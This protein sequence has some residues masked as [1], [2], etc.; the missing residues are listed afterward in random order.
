MPIVDINGTAVE[1]PDDMP[2]EALNAAVAAAA[3]QMSAS[4]SPPAAPQQFSDPGE[5]AIH[6]DAA[7]M[8]AGTLRQ[9]DPNPGVPA[10]PLQYG[11]E[12][13][14]QV[15]RGARR[16][17][18]NLVG[19]PVDLATFL[20]SSASSVLPESIRPNFD[21]RRSVGGSAWLDRALG[22]FGAVPEPPAPRDA[23]QRIAGRV[24][25]ELGALVP[26]VG[27][28][29]AAARAGAT[30]T[31]NIISRMFVQPFRANPNRYV[32]DQVETGIAAGVG[33]GAVNEATRAAGAEQGGTVQQIGDIAGSLAGGAAYAAGRATGAG[34][35]NL[36]RVARDGSEAFTSPEAEE[37][38][39]H[40]IARMFGTP[41]DGDFEAVASG[42][43]RG[44]RPG[45]AIP[46]YA[47]TLADRTQNPTVAANAYGRSSGRNA[48]AYRERAASNAEA[49]D[50]AMQGAAPEGNSGALIEAVVAERTAR[51]AGATA[52]ADRLSA[53]ADR[54]AAMLFPQMSPQERGQIVRGAL[55]DAL[56]TF[57]APQRQDA[58]TVTAELA[59]VLDGLRPSE[60]GRTPEL[61]GST[62]RS[63]LASAEGTA[64]SRV[65]ALYDEAGVG[66]QPVDSTRVA[67]ALDG[68]TN[69][70]PLAE[71]DLV[72]RQIIDNVA[73][74]GRQQAAAQAAL[75]PEAD[76]LRK[77]LEGMGD[78]PSSVARQATAVP[79]YAGGGQ[80]APP[81]TLAELTALRTRL[82]AH[83]R[84]LRADPRAE[85]GGANAA[86]VTEQYINA[87][88]DL[89]QESVDPGTAARL[90]EA[91]AAARARADSFGRQGD[92]VADVLATREGG[93]P[94][95][96]DQNVPG[97]FVNSNADAP[98]GRLLE[99][100]DTPAVR[101]AIEDELLSR[102]GR[103]PTPEAAGAVLQ[104]YG[105]ALARFPG[106]RDRIQQAVATG[107]RVTDA[108]AALASRQTEFASGSSL[109]ADA[110][111][112][113]PDG[114]PVV[115][116]EAI[117]R[118]AVSPT[119]N[120]DLD[121]ILSRAN[122]PEVRG[123]LRD[124]VL[125][126]ARV[127]R[128]PA[129][130]VEA[131]IREYAEPLKR[132]PGLADE[133]RT[134][135]GARRD[136]DA[137]AQAAEQTTR[138]LTTPGRSA[139][140]TVGSFGPDEGK[141]AIAAIIQSRNPGAATDE[142]MQAIG[143]DPEAVNGAR[144]AF[145]EYLEAKSR[146][147]GETTPTPRGTQPWMPERLYQILN[148]RSVAGVAERLYRD[149]PEHL[150][151]I[152]TIA[153]AM[154]NT[155][156]DTRGRAANSS[157][158]GQSVLQSLTPEALQSRIYA[159]QSGRISYTFLATAVV[160]V[161]YRKAMRTA[162]TAAIE[163]ITDE[164]LLNPDFA[165]A[166]LRKYNPETMRALR[167]AT[168]AASL[169][170]VSNAIDLLDQSDRDPVER[171]VSER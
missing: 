8:R 18:A 93:Q 122:T 114:I 28:A 23:P 64:Q 54:L 87:V 83:A 68:V 73:A 27:G 99:E 96:P 17:V 53:E 91:R 128:N 135:A 123:A 132:F 130:S 50:Q 21:S 155:S 10:G 81:M 88:E 82:L 74:P 39:A 150:E 127:D 165:A 15:G 97:R 137:A 162:N 107:Q 1:F 120:R 104:E 44:A 153:E 84:A 72:P 138:D 171:A 70:L 124:E 101:Q 55:A 154:R 78:V 14:V 58:E 65:A 140:G 13:V 9:S 115:P 111:R 25:E 85:S 129:D 76:E 86:R 45:Q 60:A 49:I 48:P 69:N 7:R 152:K 141:R 2:P 40:G 136:A 36:Y 131:F 167:N 24:G 159:A 118:R 100:A 126:R 117:P 42:I 158:T 142:L 57:T 4:A 169:N 51:I 6:A 46:G 71:R 35:R 143:R 47:E 103:D 170:R 56:D 147:S 33:A 75:D 145:W 113:R 38:A 20:L 112:T 102:L 148:D 108:D 66:P 156:V 106:L 121:A 59:R 61:R 32:R 133:L 19:L 151:R 63:E 89:I 26:V 166:L 157:G 98:L 160:S 12:T 43:E 146:R 105:S 139:I 3:R 163:R 134:A 119:G 41:G 116:D 62:L 52:E 94:R 125:S 11:A 31:E 29:G 67:G 149:N 92:P 30:G 37:A 144:R 77:L 79:R 80:E 22:G 95:V 90:A 164:A 16:G 5:A 168:T 109:V 34:A 161:L 110:T